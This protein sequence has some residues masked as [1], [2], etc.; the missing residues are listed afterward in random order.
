MVVMMLD[1]L[2]LF[3]VEEGILLLA[4]MM[5]KM[6][7]ILVLLDSSEVVELLD[8]VSEVVKLWDSMVAS[9]VVGEVVELADSINKVVGNNQN[10]NSPGKK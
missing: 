8:I 5:N 6:V 4:V 2:S 1:E 3:L 7:K 10:Q 9:E